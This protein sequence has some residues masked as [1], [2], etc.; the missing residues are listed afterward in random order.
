MLESETAY[1]L[2]NTSGGYSTKQ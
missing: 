2:M 1:L